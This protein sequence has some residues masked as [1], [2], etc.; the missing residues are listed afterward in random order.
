M[1]YPL[2]LYNSYD[3]KIFS[4]SDQDYVAYLASLELAASS[5][6]DLG[7]L[8]ISN[9]NSTPIGSLTNTFYQ[10]DVGSHPASTLSIGSTTSTIYQVTSPLIGESD[11]DFHH[12]VFWDSSL[13]AVREMTSAEITSSTENILTIIMRDEYPGT[14][15]LASAA[16]NSSYSVFLP[17]VFTDTSALDGSVTNYSIYI[18]TSQTAPFDEYRPIKIKRE[19]DLAGNPYQGIQLMNDNEIRKT[20]GLRAKNIINSTGIGKYLI[21][22]SSDGT[23]IEPGTWVERGVAIDTRN[24]TTEILYPELPSYTGFIADQ[25]YNTN[26]T[27]VS[28]EYLT[29]YNVNIVYD[30]TYSGAGESIQY[31]QTVFAG[32]ADYVSDVANYSTAGSQSYTGPAGGVA[33]YVPGSASNANYEAGAGNISFVGPGGTVQYLGILNYTGPGQSFYDTVG[34]SIIY[35][36]PAFEGLDTSVTFLGTSPFPDV[37]TQTQ[38]YAGPGTLNYTDIDVTVFTGTNYI[39]TITISANYTQ[40]YTNTAIYA[41]TYAVGVG[42]QSNYDTTFAAPTTVVYD[43][44]VVRQVNYTGA[45]N[46]TSTTTISTSY[47]ADT[48]YNAPSI[49]QAFVGTAFYG[50]DTSPIVEASYIGGDNYVGPETPYAAPADYTS[51]GNPVYTGVSISYDGPGYYDGTAAGIT[52][53]GPSN[54]NYTNNAGNFTG[55]L[56]NN[57]TGPESYTNEVPTSTAYNTI[58]AAQGNYDLSYQGTRTTDGFTGPVSYGGLSFQNDGYVGLTGTFSARATYDGTP[59]YT[60]I[61]DIYQGGGTFIG[62]EY[63]NNIFYSPQFVQS[64]SQIYSGPVAPVPGELA[65][66]VT[67]AYQ[68]PNILN[69]NYTSDI[70]IYV[71]D[72]FIAD[73]VSAN[74]YTGGGAPYLGPGAFAGPGSLLYF[75]GST[76]ANYTSDTAVYS[77]PDPAGQ[78][79]FGI[80]YAGPIVYV[81]P[82]IDIAY[83]TETGVYTR[84]DIVNYENPDIAIYSSDTAG[85]F[86]TTYVT[87]VPTTYLGLANYT[88]AGIAVF[89][90]PDY[91]ADGFY[92]AGAGFVGPT[93]Y[94]QTIMYASPGP[95]GNYTR[96]NDANYTRNNAVPLITYIKTDSYT[97]LGPDTNYTRQAP[98][99]NYD[100]TDGITYVGGVSVD[101][102]TV[103]SSIYTEGAAI[104]EGTTI[105]VSTATIETYTLYC[106]VA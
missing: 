1:V 4:D 27:N 74:N 101:Y 99:I 61:V 6:T 47:V 44:E 12:P 86:S 84:E 46:Y 35:T 13:S 70:A 103:Y 55:L 75:A 51:I 92:V 91:V 28:P 7:A 69:V 8:T 76:G 64:D 96:L 36:G 80:V 31:E 22:S 94:T 90:G 23:P 10:Q 78:D 3:L 29:A 105:D 66:Y 71:L 40:A 52:F 33:N 26:Y 62:G 88:G 58:I 25:S 73:F 87:I 11:G 72:S 85:V 20:F 81:G 93:N 49:A 63:P 50:S 41:S 100:T 95:A 102:N 9:V 54:E 89:I 18:K 67:I 39:R 19:D 37:Y 42:Y 17:N 16:P 104:F 98:D 60:R 79:S 43:S 14:F 82:P 56:A 59:N 48:V 34:I 68:G 24:T 57:Y 5:T 2:R 15:R 38:T 21:K 32:P 53:T 77:E 45:I 83:S 106:R 65:D 97:A 30:V